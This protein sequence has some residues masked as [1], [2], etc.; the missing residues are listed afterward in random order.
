MQRRREPRRFGPCARTT[1]VPCVQS[2]HA[3]LHTRLI[4]HSRS[5]ARRRDM[6]PT[7]SSAASRSPRRAGNGPEGRSGTRPDLWPARNM[8]PT[9]SPT[10]SRVRRQAWNGPRWLTRHS[11]APVAG[12]RYATNG[13]TSGK[14]CPPPGVE[15]PAMV[16]AALGRTCRRPA[17]CNQR[18]HQR[19]VVSAARRG[20][21]PRRARHRCRRP[22]PPGGRLQ[23]ASQRL[24]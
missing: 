6:Q 23:N 20:T 24:S 4:G 16:D 7:A 8:Q 21:G 22:V 5:V 19:Q 13:I 15:R 10:A 17:I 3:A 18:H 12:P 1:D 11:A 2:N 14:S 9:A